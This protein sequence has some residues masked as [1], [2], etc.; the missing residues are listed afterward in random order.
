MKNVVIHK[1]VKFIFTED[2]LKGYWKRL[3]EDLEFSSLSNEQLILLANKMFENASHSQ[4]EQHISEGIWRTKEDV[5]GHLL[6]EDDSKEDVHVE[7]IDTSKQVV[8]AQKV[9]IDRF[10]KMDCASCSF[11]F[12]VQNLETDPTTLSCPSCNSKIN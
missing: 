3:G 12:Y 4:L 10:L 11:T 2:Q 8:S 1:I 6:A 7:L 5:T 9:I